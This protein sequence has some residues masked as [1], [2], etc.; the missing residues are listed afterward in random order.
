M[1]M[2]TRGIYNLLKIFAIFVITPT[3]NLTKYPL[4]LHIKSHKTNNA[5]GVVCFYIFVNLCKVSLFTKTCK[6][7]SITLKKIWNCCNHGQKP[8]YKIS[9][10]TKNKQ[11]TC[12][13]I[14]RTHYWSN[15]SLGKVV[16]SWNATSLIAT[17]T[18]DSQ[19]RQRLTK[20]RAKREA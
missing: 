19:P 5:F 13:Q 7:K 9:N 17:L 11:T 4:K 18:F 1:S 8:Y 10:Q 14:K 20:V 2:D 3:Y 15:A 12:N 6:S 16:Q